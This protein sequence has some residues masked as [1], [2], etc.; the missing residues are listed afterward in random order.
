MT[1]PDSVTSIGNYAFYDCSGLTNV[2]FEGNAPSVGSYV[3]SYVNSS[4]VVYVPRGS[5]GWGV[6]IPGTWNGLAIRYI[7]ND[8]MVVFDIGNHGVRTG[9]GE[10]EQRVDYQ[11]AALAP[12]VVGNEGW[13]FL[14]WDADFSCVTSNM[15]VNALWRRV[16]TAGEMFGGEWAVGTNGVAAAKGYDDATAAGGKSL[17]F[18]AADDA[19][20][21]VEAV[22]TNA[23]RVSF[24]WKSSCEPLVKGH[25]YDYFAFTVDGEQQN[26]VCGETG[27]TSATN[28]V[29]GAGEHVL[30]WTFQRDEE[31]SAGE[32]SAW[33][34][35]VVVTPSVSLVFAAGG[36]TAGSVPEPVSGYADESVVLPGLGSLAWP[37][38]RFLG[39]GDGTAIYGEGTPYSLG[40]A[41]LLTA[42]WAAN[43]LAAPVITAPETYEADSVTVT[44]T[45]EDG[46]SIYYTL[47]GSEPRTARSV[48]APYQWV[49][50]T[51]STIQ[52]QGSFAVVGS[53]T[54]KAI[55]VKEDYFDSEV[56]SATVTRLPW[57]FG[58]YL[59]WPEQ[60]FTTG[61]AAE[62]VR[63][64]GVSVDGFALRSGAITHS[65]TSRLETVVSGPGSI[66]FSCKV[67]GEIVK[68]QVWDGLAFCVDGVQQGDLMG[69]VN[70][71]EQTFEVTGEGSHT[72]SWLYVKDE[73]GN[74]D[75]EDCA[76]LDAVSWTPSA[77]D[78]LAAWLAE[79]NLTADAVAANGRTAAECYVLGLD[80]TL[81]TN[82]FRI[83]SIEMVDGK[84]KVEW[85]PKVNRWTGAELKA[86][87]KGAERLEGPWEDVP[88]GGA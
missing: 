4:C 38:H 51:S 53:A 81:A 82:D 58:E 48:I 65:Q 25:A 15:V 83:V 60:T 78:G 43:T 5:T 11:A 62:W 22:V 21:W 71:A 88:E 63:V 76:W 26:C 73:E 75:G 70:W 34:A 49:P 14:G 61:G 24:D 36:A 29:T 68:K 6:S 19:L 9:G 3:F 42:Q 47:D 35:N 17:K 28:Y 13:E 46:A 77:S 7:E 1:I 74:G 45:A 79:R 72:L 85:E 31:G 87:L 32:D 64:K 8:S 2:V 86:V 69:N 66:T 67:E 37:K 30:R 10:L 56:A 50:D 40:G 57:T 20:A 12:E 55:A 18:T 23:C 54:V 16:Y 44:I 52:Y 41:L 84:P 27:W 59:N 80:P 33:L 39:W